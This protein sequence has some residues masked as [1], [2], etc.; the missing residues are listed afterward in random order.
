[1]SLTKK[2]RS[3]TRHTL[4][5][6]IEAGRERERTTELR[7]ENEEKRETEVV[8]GKN[9]LLLVV[10]FLYISRHSFLLLSLSLFLRFFLSLKN[11][12][13]HSVIFRVTVDLQHVLHRYFSCE[14]ISFSTAKDI[15]DRISF[16]TFNECDSNHI[17]FVVI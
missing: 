6:E 5:L 4:T 10:L 15:D 2:T 9:K 1:M 11:A 3:N 12:H 8:K 14:L 17:G 13:R 7:A 16:F